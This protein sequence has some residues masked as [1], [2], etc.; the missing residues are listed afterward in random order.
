MS[1]PENSPRL[2]FVPLETLELGEH[3]SGQVT[4]VVNAFWAVHPEK[5]IV[6]WGYGRKSPQ[7]YPQYNPDLAVATKLASHLYPWAEVKKIPL[8]LLRSNGRLL[9][10]EEC[11]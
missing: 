6:V 2:T 8:V 5:G 10:K 1:L 9:T 11:K 3:Y 4:A 7:V